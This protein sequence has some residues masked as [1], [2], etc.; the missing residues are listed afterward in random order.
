[1]HKI[2]CICLVKSNSCRFEYVQ[3]LI[4]LGRL[5]TELSLICSP[6]VRRWFSKTLIF[7]KNVKKLVWASQIFTVPVNQSQSSSS[8]VLSFI[9]F[10][11]F[12]WFGH[13]TL[14]KKTGF[15]KMAFITVES[16]CWKCIERSGCSCCCWWCNLTWLHLSFNY[17]LSKLSFTSA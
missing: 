7:L 17:H 6:V 14:N 3:M 10:S 15:R 9:T 11:T 13:Y 12:L 8:S 2:N 4:P 16:S 5:H 1:M